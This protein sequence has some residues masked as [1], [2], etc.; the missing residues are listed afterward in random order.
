MFPVVIFEGFHG[1]GRRKI[2][3]LCYTPRFVSWERNVSINPKKHLGFVAR[4]AITH[5]MIQGRIQ[6]FNIGGGGEIM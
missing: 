2:E 1:G 6:D 4:H 3:R 5:C